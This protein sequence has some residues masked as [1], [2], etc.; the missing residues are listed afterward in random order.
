MF[1]F[2]LPNG[3]KIGGQSMQYTW[4]LGKIVRCPPQWFF[5]YYFFYF[6]FI[7]ALYI[8]ACMPVFS[9]KKRVSD[10]LVL[11]YSQLWATRH[12]GDQTPVLKEQ[13]SVLNL[14]LISSPPYIY[15]IICVCL[16]LYWLC[17]HVWCM[18]ACRHKSTM[19]RL[20]DNL[21]ELVFFTQHRFLRLK[22][23]I[24]RPDGKAFDC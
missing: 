16:C 12:T 17:L 9:C 19:W 6:L 1:F 10:S 13:Q 21:Q 11:T 7:S 14:W 23:Q 5:S 15:F 4:R 3:Q 8:C 22:T 2:D 18:S 24:I 20:K